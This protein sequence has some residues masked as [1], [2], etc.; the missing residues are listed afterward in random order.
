VPLHNKESQHQAGHKTFYY[1]CNN[2]YYDLF[3]FISILHQ[4]PLHN[5]ESWYQTGH[6]T[7]LLTSLLL[8][9][10]SLLLLLILI[11]LNCA[12]DIA[13]QQEVAGIDEAP[14]IYLFYFNLFNF[15]YLN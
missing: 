6:Q 3:Q 13:P 1:Y 10:L 2:Y 14:D 15:I 11:Y 12:S 8:L 7:I 9:L 4:V 5:K